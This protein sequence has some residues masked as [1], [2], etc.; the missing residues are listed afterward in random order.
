ML[1]GFDFENVAGVLDQG[2]LVAAAGAQERQGARASILYCPKSA[3]SIAIRASRNTPDAANIPPRAGV[4]RNDGLGADPLRF[5]PLLACLVCQ[6]ERRID[7]S[8]RQDFGI[9]I[10]DQGNTTAR[11]RNSAAGGQEGVL[12]YRLRR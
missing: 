3:L 6:C 1:S 7:R 5:E 10:A 9:E 11:H 12:K 8:V 4:V 2:M